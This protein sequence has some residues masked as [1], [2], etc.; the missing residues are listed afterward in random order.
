MAGVLGVSVAVPEAVWDWT[1]G[2]GGAA[3]ILLVGGAVLLVASGVGRRL[4][5]AGRP[6][7]AAG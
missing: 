3:G 2:A 5:R 4:H 6:R 7:R 1:D